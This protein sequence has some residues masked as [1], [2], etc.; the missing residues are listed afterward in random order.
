M[1]G[2]VGYVTLCVI[3]CSCWGSWV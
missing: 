3:V 1:V 2:K